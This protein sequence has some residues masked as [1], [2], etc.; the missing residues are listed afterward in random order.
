MEIS[1]VE[2]DDLKWAVNLIDNA[3]FLFPTYPRRTIRNQGR[4]ISTVEGDF[5]IDQIREELKRRNEE[6]LECPEK[7]PNSK[8]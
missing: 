1:E 4:I 6:K 7:C 3:L 8:S 2:T 5:N